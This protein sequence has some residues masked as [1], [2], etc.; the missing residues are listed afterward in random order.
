VVAVLVQKSVL[1][2][3]FVLYQSSQVSGKRLGVAVPLTDLREF[4]MAVLL[5]IGVPEDEASI[6][7]ASLL[8]ADLRG[9]SSHGVARLAGYIKR[10][11][12]GL[13]QAATDFKV[14]KQSE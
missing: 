8:E 10:I 6:V 1:N 14:E 2:R 12:L 3:P 7:T 13:M 9:T 4:V 11:R 5:R